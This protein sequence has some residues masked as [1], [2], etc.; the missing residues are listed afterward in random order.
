MNIMFYQAVAILHY[1][2]A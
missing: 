2:R 1:A